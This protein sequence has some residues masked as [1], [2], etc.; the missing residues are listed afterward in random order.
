MSETKEFYITELSTNDDHSFTLGIISGTEEIERLYRVEI[1]LNSHGEL[2]GLK[3]E[4]R[5]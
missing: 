4:K 5:S 1:R 3:S 2:V